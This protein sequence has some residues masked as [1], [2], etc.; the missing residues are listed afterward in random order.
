M[1][2]L[3]FCITFSVIYNYFILIF[4]FLLFI[5]LQI[6]SMH[7]NVNVCEWVCETKTDRTAYVEFFFNE[8]CASIKCQTMKPFKLFW[9]VHLNQVQL[10]NSFYL[11]KKK[12]GKKIQ[13]L[14]NITNMFMWKIDNCVQLKI[15]KGEKEK[16]KVN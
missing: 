6:N 14:N 9:N 16:R 11:R 3:L 2:I 1:I 7:V 5:Q 13:K 12:K 8:I 15:A 4:F 10:F